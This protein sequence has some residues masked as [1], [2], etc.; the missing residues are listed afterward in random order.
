M[1]IEMCMPLTILTM[2]FVL[3][4]RMI[5]VTEYL[6]KIIILDETARAPLV[7]G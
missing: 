6:L 7:N 4:N 5:Y 1:L 2:I 3:L